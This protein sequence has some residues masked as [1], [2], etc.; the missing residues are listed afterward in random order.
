M[1]IKNMLTKINNLNHNTFDSNTMI[2][3]EQK[4]YSLTE[5]FSNLIKNAIDNIN[6]IQNN[7]IQ[8]TKDFDA[9]KPGTSL[10]QVIID[11]E[12]STI[13]IQMAVQI[14]NKVISAYKDIMNMQL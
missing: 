8:T 1:F 12:K 14:K 3:K 13:A 10:N 9:N 2:M 6:N 11:I 4:N 7:A 5:N